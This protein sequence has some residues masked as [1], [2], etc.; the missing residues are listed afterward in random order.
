MKEMQQQ[1]YLNLLRWKWTKPKMNG[2]FKH[3][4]GV[5]VHIHNPSISRLTQE[6][7]HMFMAITVYLVHFRSAV[8]KEQVYVKRQN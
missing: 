1:S 7:S 5:V 2:Y 8:A 6:D 3:K 4:L